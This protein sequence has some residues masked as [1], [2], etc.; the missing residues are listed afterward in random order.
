[1]AIWL[2]GTRIDMPGRTIMERTFFEDVALS[3]TTL[4]R[5]LVR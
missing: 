1:M 2:V 3:R 4:P 5:K